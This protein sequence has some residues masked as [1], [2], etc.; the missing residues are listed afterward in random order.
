MEN[1]NILIEYD[2][3][4]HFFPVNFGGMSDEKALAVHNQ[5]KIRDGIKNAWAKKHGIRLIRIKFSDDV[6][7]VLQ[8]SLSPLSNH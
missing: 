8:K 4:Q 7:D 6:D 5:I 1:E 2:G 3:Q